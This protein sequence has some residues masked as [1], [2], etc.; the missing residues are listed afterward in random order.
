[1]DSGGSEEPCVIGWGPDSP[2]GRG[3]FGG[4]CPST[5]HCNSESAENGYIINYTMYR[6][7]LASAIYGYGSFTYRHLH[8]REKA[9]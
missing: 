5:M 3:S 1:M 8:L 7:R 6:Q 4:R 9:V 2:R